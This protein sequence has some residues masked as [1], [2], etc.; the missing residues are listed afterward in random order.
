MGEMEVK[1]DPSF[2]FSFKLHSNRPL[3][4]SSSN[5]LK[6]SE[7]LK[8]GVGMDILSS[9]SSFLSARRQTN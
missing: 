1:D 5:G 6:S 8:K 3:V 9:F 7:L 4:N 2:I